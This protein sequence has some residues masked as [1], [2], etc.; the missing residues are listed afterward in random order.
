M[1][2]RCAKLAIMAVRTR[3]KAA[4]TRPPEGNRFAL[5][6]AVLVGTYVVSA[7]IT[8]PLIRTL[9]IALLLGVVLIAVQVS[10]ISR[11]ITRLAIAVVVGGS[12]AALVLVRTT[13]SDPVDGAASAWIALMLLFA[14]ILIVRKVLTGKEV[15]LQSIFGAISA[16]LII[17]LM[18]AAIYGAMSKFG[19]GPFFADGQPE[20]A[21]TFQY[22]SFTTLTTVGYGD[23]TAAAASGRAVAV[24]EAVLGQVFLA[25]LVGWLVSAFRAPRFSGDGDDARRTGH[26]RPVP[27]RG[28]A[29]TRAAVKR[30]YRHRPARPRSPTG[31]PRVVRDGSSEPR[32][33]A[34]PPGPKTD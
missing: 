7:F 25:V 16:Y 19:S 24:M 9:Q 20:S 14:V 8:G 15:T 21:A 33:Q 13:T 2:G 28:R 17:G 26:A 11:R 18:F 34:R 27:R 12:A 31:E 32:R 30:P 23:F 1:A 6:L 5:L 22:F 29:A 4:T 3:I 10:G